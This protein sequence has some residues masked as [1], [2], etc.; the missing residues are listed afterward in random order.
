L[1]NVP[2]DDLA[3][4]PAA[5]SYSESNDTL[6]IIYTGSDAGNALNVGDPDPKSHAY[7]AGYVPN[8]FKDNNRKIEF[9]DFSLKI[10][11]NPSIIERKGKN[12]IIF[13]SSL[14]ITIIDA[15]E[16]HNLKKITF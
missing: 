10:G 11:S 16:S 4:N 6:Y 8:F 3:Y 5:F 12:Q 9:D 2:T 1:P 15:S 7:F 14:G 13:V